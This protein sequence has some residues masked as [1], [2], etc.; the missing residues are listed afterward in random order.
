MHACLTRAHSE[1]CMPSKQ[2]T[3]TPSNVPPGPEVL[4]GSQPP[5]VSGGGRGNAYAQGQIPPGTGDTCGYTVQG[6]D[7]LWNIAQRNLGS[8]PNWRDIYNTNRDA[9][10][11]NPDLIHPGLELNLC[12]TDANMSGGGPLQ[13]STTPLEDSSMTP[14]QH[15]EIAQAAR[16]TLQTRVDG[17]DRLTPEHR[18]R[19]MNRVSGLEGEA[20]VAE[21]RLIEHALA[22]PNGDRAL[23]AYSTVHGMI[24]GDESAAERLTPE[25]IEMMVNGVADRRTESDR[26][27]E[28]VLGIRQV[29]NSATAL[30]EMSDDQYADTMEML[31]SAGEDEEGNLIQGASPGTEQALILKAISSRQDRLETNIFQDLWRWLGGDTD[32]DRALREIRGFADNIRGEQRDDLIRTTTLLDIDD[33]NTS[34]INPDAIAANNDTTTNNDGLYQRFHDSC[35]PTT[36]QIIRGESDPI[37]A[38]RIHDEGINNSDPHSFSG[39]QQLDTLHTHGGDSRS[40][41]GT[42]ALSS[43]NNTA[44]T[45]EGENAITAGQRTAFD[46][47]TA[48][49]PLTEAQQ[50][51]ADAAIAAIRARNGGHPTDQELR[52][53]RENNG[54]GNTGAW[55]HDALNSIASEGTGLTYTQRAVTGGSIANDLTTID[56]TLFNGDEVPFH[57][58]WAGGG[59]HAMSIQDVRHNADGTR[60]Y[61]VSDPHA[62][63]TAWVSQADLVA[64]RVPLGNGNI[65]LIGVGQEQ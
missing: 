2:P 31:N 33:V 51:D 50:T 35:A 36:A 14:E 34:T 17:L 60:M 48:G 8:G 29:R 63:D 22:G 10:G 41:E 46:R 9:V 4:Q 18:Q 15:L 19:V 16:D 37:F 54:R 13:T 30:L 6:G 59:A 27:Q 38:R 52:S 32:S 1:T 28:G 56:E 12:G 40:R 62:G 44:S 49:Q 45:L 7:S 55:Q 61:L 24:E 20:L 42:Q 57:I 3:K 26:G 58:D 25:V 21:M 43:A 65:S 5:E 39:E 64:G 23:A 47:L 53:I 11:D